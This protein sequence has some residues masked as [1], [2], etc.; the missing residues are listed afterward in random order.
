MQPLLPWL[1]ALALSCPPALAGTP[2][3]VAGWRIEPLPAGGGCLA[4][5]GL[6]DG[7]ALR[8]RLDA[9]GGTGALHVIAPGWGPLIEGDAYDFLYDLDGNVTEAEGMG[10]Y[11]EARPGVLMALAS[12]DV[13]DRLAETQ[14]LRIYFGEAEIVTAALN[15]SAEAVAAARGCA[16][17]QDG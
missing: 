4:S 7:A 17:V 11:L 6:A 16:G 15:G 12:A 8:L 9:T 13:V 3:H 5:R 1:L 10:R 14:V 2:Q